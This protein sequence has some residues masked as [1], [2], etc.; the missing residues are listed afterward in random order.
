MPGRKPAPSAP[1]RAIRGGHEAQE[2]RVGV[3]VA[4]DV[5][6]RGRQRRMAGKLLHVRERATGC[7]DVLGAARH[8]LRRPLWLD[9][10]A[11]PRLAVK[12]VKPHLH[13]TGRHADVGLGMHDGIGGL[14]V[15]SGCL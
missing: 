6:L 5:P 11:K 1:T 15:V 2:E 3:H 8:E 14:D 10:P 7:N 4:L 13:R 9:A 12:P